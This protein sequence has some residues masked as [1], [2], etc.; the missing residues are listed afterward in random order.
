MKRSLPG[1]QPS[2]LI[3]GERALAAGVA[4]LLGQLIALVLGGAARALGRRGILLA[5][6][7]VRLQA[8]DLLLQVLVLGQ[9]VVLAGVRLLR[10]PLDFLRE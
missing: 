7:Q 6:H 4:E 1:V 2:L 8:L 9:H 10:V 5:L 3:Q